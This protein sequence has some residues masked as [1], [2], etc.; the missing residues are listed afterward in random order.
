[1][2]PWVICCRQKSFQARQIMFELLLPML[3]RF[4]G[5]VLR[6]Y[7][8]PAGIPTIGIGSTVYENGVKVKL[9]DPP[10]T[11]ER[12]I[13]LCRITVERDYLP[14]VMSLCPELDSPERVAAIVD[15]T[16]NLGV[17]ALRTSTLRKK[18]NAR[19]W[20]EVPAQ[21]NRWVHSSSGVLSGLVA[22]RKFEGLA[23]I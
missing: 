17:S 8:C 18:I 6:P 22:R 23:F 1:M 2:Y 5:V 14:A 11:R 20:D 13:E 7:L 12:A 15:F 9:T 21:L 19:S 10:I 3:I 16:Y 4:E